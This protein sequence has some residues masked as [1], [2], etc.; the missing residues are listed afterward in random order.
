MRC[1]GCGLDN[2]EGVDACDHCGMD[3]AGLDLPEARSG[4]RGRMLGDRLGDLV[5]AQAVQID[6]ASSVGEAIAA[7]RRQGCGCVLVLRDGKLAG[8]FNERHVLTRIVRPGRD[9]ETTSMAEVMSPDP[10]R[11]SP[12][13]PPAHAVHCMV[14]RGYRHLAVVEG[15]RILGYVSVREILS[16]ITG[17]DNASGL[18]S[19][20]C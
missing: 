11:L 7:M 1:P 10:L 3:L 6:V 15:E 17:L 4:F 18:A 19:A 2:I 20:G 8:I 9:P 12:E 16:Y 13:D 5:L 14:A